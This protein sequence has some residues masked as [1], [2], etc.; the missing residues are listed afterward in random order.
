MATI[1]IENPNTEPVDVRVLGKS[2]FLGLSKQDHRMH[3]GS[4]S[5]G[6]VEMPPGT[7]YIRYKYKNSTTFEGDP[8]SLEKDSAVKITL[9]ASP[10][11]NYGIRASGEDL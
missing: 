7:F 3:V 8:F 10:S 11:G 5:L 6:S 2:G 9:V 1:V 4:S